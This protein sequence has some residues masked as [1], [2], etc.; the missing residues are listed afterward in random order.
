MCEVRGKCQL[1]GAYQ[2]VAFVYHDQLVVGICCNLLKGLT[3]AGVQWMRSVLAL[4]AEFEPPLRALA[5]DAVES[6]RNAAKD[7]LEDES[8]VG[9]T[10]SAF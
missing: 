5:E 4:R 7:E 3:V 8:G 2:F 10:V 6:V 9:L 1:Q